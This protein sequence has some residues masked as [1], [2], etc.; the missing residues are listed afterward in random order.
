[1][2]EI[3]KFLKMEYQED[4]K[5]IWILVEIILLVLA[6]YLRGSDQY[7]I[8]LLIG[9]MYIGSFLVSSFHYRTGADTLLL[10]NGYYQ[11]KKG[12][13]FVV[14]CFLH[15]ILLEVGIYF[16]LFLSYGISITAIIYGTI[17]CIF[18]N[19]IGILIGTTVKKEIVGLG[20]C[21]LLIGI[22]FPKLLFQ[23][24]YLRFFSPVVQVGNINKLQWWNLLVLLIFGI[25]VIAKMILQEK[26]IIIVAGAAILLVIG[27]DIWSHN[28]TLSVP[29]EYEVYVEGIL[30]GINKVNAECGM[31]EYED[32]V[33]YKETYYPWESN[34]EKMVFYQKDTTLYLNC[35]TESL[36]NMEKD[37]IILRWA[38]ATLNAKNKYQQAVGDMY[39][40]Y[41]IGNEEFINQFTYE[42]QIKEYG[43]VVTPIYGLAVEIIQNDIERYGELNKFAKECK[44]GDDIVKLWE[45]REENNE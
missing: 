7:G 26:D 1:M 45:E 28:K 27:A 5:F 23:E 31:M 15:N 20:I 36:C 32:I 17:L 40:Q 13:L 9:G 11:K 44:E 2:G 33:I 3:K 29:K 19:A 30:D 12:F 14:G 10:G 18:T 24:E 35:F 37:E 41:L 21:V 34:R 42:N 22:N 4:G 38:A 8:A 43:K 6:C 16:Y 39:A 25:A